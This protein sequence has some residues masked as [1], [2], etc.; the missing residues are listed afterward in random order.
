M[1]LTNLGRALFTLLCFGTFVIVSW[2][3]YSK[4]SKKRYDEV[5]SMVIDDD[6]SPSDV[7]GEEPSN[8]A[9]Q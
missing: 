4:S 9:K 6:D 5:A 8:G 7:A 3:A 2:V 1:D